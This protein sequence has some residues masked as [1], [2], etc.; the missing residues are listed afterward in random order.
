MKMT[1][2]LRSSCFIAATLSTTV[3]AL[4][5][6]VPVTPAYVR[7]HPKEWSVK[8]SKGKDDLIDFTIK[9]DVARPM[10]H[11]AH[12][13]VYLQ[14]RLIATSDTPSYG[15]KQGNTFFFSIAAEDLPDSKFSL[16]DSAL[17]GSGDNAVPVP[18]TIIHEFRLSDFV[19]ERML[20]SAVG[21]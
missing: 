7:E 20:K 9:H 21:K 17:A 19:P 5:I 8:V 13:E 15:K 14:G 3:W 12:L 6:N 11:V 18:G 10:Y 4:T 2:L 1:A 16:S